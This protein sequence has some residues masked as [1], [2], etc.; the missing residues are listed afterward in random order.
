[1][2]RILNVCLKVSWFSPHCLA[3][4]SSGHIDNL[5]VDISTKFAITL[6]WVEKN[7]IWEAG[8]GSSEILV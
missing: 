7:L 8:L 2:Y 5:I 1:M 6:S 4:E 3:I